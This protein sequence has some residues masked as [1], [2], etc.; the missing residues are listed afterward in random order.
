VRPY[1]YLSKGIRNKV[2]VTLRREP[3]RN[4]TPRLLNVREAA[5][6]ISRTPKALKHMIQ[7]NKLPVVRCG[8]RVHIDKEVLDKWIRE[9]TFAL[10]VVATVIDGCQ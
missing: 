4:V 3:V 5:S 6:Y 1:Y 7:R 9:C 8:R 10:A 2:R